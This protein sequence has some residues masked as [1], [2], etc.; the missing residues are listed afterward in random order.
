MVKMSILLL[1][2]LLLLVVVFLKAYVVGYREKHENTTTSHKCY[3]QS[4]VAF[5]VPCDSEWCLVY[6]H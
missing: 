2:L 1:L 6:S 4:Y 5:T 3:S